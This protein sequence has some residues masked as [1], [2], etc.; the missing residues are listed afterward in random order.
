M[1]QPCWWR[2]G[3]TNAQ[4]NGWHLTRPFTTAEKAGNQF[5]KPLSLL[6]HIFCSCTSPGH[7]WVRGS[8]I[9]VPI[10]LLRN[11]KNSHNSPAVPSWSSKTHRN[12]NANRK[13]FLFNPS[14]FGSSFLVKTAVLGRF[15]V[16]VSMMSSVQV[17]FHSHC[18]STCF[19]RSSLGTRGRLQQF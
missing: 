11:P 8:G 7:C 16:R 12:P 18:C 6:C 10:T 4:T 15:N 14:I 19:L 17:G 3:N 13:C 2:G 5:P 1:V 9:F